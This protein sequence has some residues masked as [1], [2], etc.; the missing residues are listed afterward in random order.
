LKSLNLVPIQA[1]SAL[2]MGTVVEA[3]PSVKILLVYYFVLYSIEVAVVAPL[4]VGT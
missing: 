3:V 2:P 1:A 4:A